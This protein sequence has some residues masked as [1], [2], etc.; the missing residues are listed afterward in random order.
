MRPTRRGPAARARPRC[1]TSA[2]DVPPAT[3]SRPSR[4]LRAPRPARAG[5]GRA[6]GAVRAPPRWPRAGPRAGPGRWREA[7]RA[8]APPRPPRCGERDRPP[9]R[10]ARRG[11]RSAILDLEALLARVVSAGAAPRGRGPR[12]AAARAGPGRHAGAGVMAA[13]EALLALGGLSLG[14]GHRV[15]GL[16][17]GTGGVGRALARPEIQ[18]GT[19]PGAEP[20]AVLATEREEVHRED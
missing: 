9:S 5:S 20:P 4:S 15:L 6:P 10:R 18:I 14:D 11:S 19:A 16:G 2:C 7:P 17:V 8:P 13:A 1:W 12:R 3:A